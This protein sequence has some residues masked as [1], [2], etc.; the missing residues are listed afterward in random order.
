MHLS[1]T[2]LAHIVSGTK[3]L[4]ASLA[5]ALLATGCSQN[6]DN[7]SHVNSSSAASASASASNSQDAAKA[8]DS[9]KPSDSA[10]SES[11]ASASASQAQQK[12]KNDNNDD[13]GEDEGNGKDPKSSATA[14]SND[15]KLAENF[16]G[17][18]KLASAKTVDTSHEQVKKTQELYSSF[19][20]VLSNVGTMDRPGS[21]DDEDKAKSGESTDSP[22]K[23]IDDA[24]QKKIDAVSTGSAKDEFSSS[25][26]EYATAGKKQEGK[27]TIVGQPK[28]ADTEYNGQPAKILEVCIDSSKV[29][30]KDSAGNDMLD[31][32]APKRSLNVFTLVED[33]GSWKIASH[34]FPNNPDC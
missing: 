26:L 20:S 34:D 19:E 7:A 3:V 10:S 15:P 29:K 33:N 1:H 6:A 24:T 14:K 25:A 16:P 30:V 32:H 22:S 17:A 9:A 2:K 28:I 23:T 18:D 13:Q 12:K 4:S 11:K 8:S 5:L 27:S 21:T 31:S